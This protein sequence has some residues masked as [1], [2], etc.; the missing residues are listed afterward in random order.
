MQLPENARVVLELTPVDAEG[1]VLYVGAVEPRV[2]GA[3]ELTADRRMALE[4]ATGSAGWAALELRAAAQ[5]RVIPLAIGQPRHA[6]RPIDDRH[7]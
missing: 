3:A 7:L 4:L 6:A 1:R 2:S 5:T